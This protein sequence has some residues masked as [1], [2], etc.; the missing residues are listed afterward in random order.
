MAL[1]NFPNIKAPSYPLD[2]VPEDAVI[3]SSMEDGTVKTRA[4]FTKNRFT[5]TLTWLALPNN[6]KIALEQFLR[7]TTKNGA[8]AFNWTHPSGEQKVVRLADMPVFSLTK[9][10]YW[11]VNIKLQEV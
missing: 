5:Y 1:I 6:D 9:V 8:L 2:E 10:N 3:R 4:K 7:V 11:R